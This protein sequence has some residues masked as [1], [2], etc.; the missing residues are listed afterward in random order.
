MKSVR[1]KSIEIRNYRQFVEQKIDLTTNEDKNTIVIVGNNGYGKSNIFNA[2]NWCFFGVEEHLNPDDRSLP[3]CN[4]NTFIKM[5]KG[6]LEES[7]VKIEM[8]T[9]IGKKIIE[10]Q[11]KTEKISENKAN[12]FDTKLKVMEC[13][14]NDWKISPFPEYSISRILP[15]DMKNFFFIDGEKLRQLFEKCNPKDIKKSIFDLSQ[16]TLL[17][18]A[19]DHLNYVKRSIRSAKAGIAP[20]LE[21]YENALKELENKI[22]KNEELLEKRKQDVK[23]MVKN[24]DVL[25]DKLKRIKYEEL[26]KLEGERQRLEERIKGLDASLNRENK[27]YFEYLFDIAPSIICRK[28]IG[29]ALKI[30][31]KISEADKLPPKIEATFIEELLKKGVC[32]CGSDLNMDNNMEKRKR[33]E[34]IISENAKYSNITENLI[35]LK[36]SLVNMRKAEDDFNNKS[37]EYEKTIKEIEDE[38]KGCQAR[39][40]DVKTK[41]GEIDI[42]KVQKINT[43]RDNVNRALNQAD[44]EIGQLKENIRYDNESH[45]KIEAD[46]FREMKK[47]K[48]Y[49]IIVKKMEICDG[50]I[51]K[52]V[53]VKD[54]IMDEI[55]EEIQKNT[56]KYFDNMI[57]EKRFGTFEITPEYDLIIEQDGF[58]AITSLSAAETLCMGYSFMSAL[59]KSSNFTAP[60]IIDTP[61]AKIGTEYRK[62][63]ADW[64]IKSL[65]DAQVVLLVTDTEYT[66]EFRNAIKSKISKEYILKYDEKT[67]CSE[68]KRYVR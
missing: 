11:M 48:A 41:L 68:V 54:K 4:S 34:K 26:A 64:F 40:K 66:D 29:D 65:Y 55:R 62:N 38:N 12:A 22:K 59:R 9:E 42:E 39:L 35:N 51:E 23:S 32:I 8:E 21:E 25:S 47:K 57:S 63:V 60:V 46:Y 52:L 37:I 49:N 56:K 5:K 14:G 33:L 15:E 53:K 18:N 20:V 61:L 36:Y 1:L 6:S 44:S 30:I 2:I 3:I 27:D 7:I 45:Q 31:L 43:E 50:G 10:R 16:I 58:N 67:K 17:Q 24:R 13:I 19:I 28:S